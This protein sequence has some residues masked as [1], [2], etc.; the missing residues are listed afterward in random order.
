M[1]LD[2][3]EVYK[4][5]G[6]IKALNGVI[7]K[8]DKGE[9]RGLIGPNGSGKTTLLNVINGIYKVTKGEIYFENKPIHNLPPYEVAKRG[10]GRVFQIIKVFKNL[11]VWEN[12]LVPA[13]TN[14][15]IYRDQDINEAARE[16]LEIVGLYRLKD[17]LA[18]NLSGG[19]QKLLEFARALMLRPRLMLLDEPFAGVHPQIKEKMINVIKQLNNS[20]NMTFLVVSHDITSVFNLCS[21]VSVLFEGRVLCEGEP[22]EVRGDE[23]VLEAYLGG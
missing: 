4:F 19:Q 8:V 14:R 7:L 3:R 10:I 1:L 6:G 9:I 17:E 23:R 12:L 16:A 5:F 21:Y 13:Y 22:V 18:K 15:K 20:D 11:T 2:V